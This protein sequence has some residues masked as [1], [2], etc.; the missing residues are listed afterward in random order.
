MKK[1]VSSIL[2]LTLSMAVVAFPHRNQDPQDP[3]AAA[4]PHP[5]ASA[6][7]TALTNKE[8]LEMMKAG[9]TAD[10]IV[11]KI[12]SSETNFDTTPAAL[13]ELKAANVPDTVILA[14]VKG[15]A[16]VPAGEGVVNV[17][18]GTEVEIQLTNNASGEELKVGNV[19]DFV[20]V[21]PV[22]V[23]GV[24][25][26]EKGAG[27]RARITTAKRAGHWGKAGKLEWAM[28]DVMAADG[29]RIPARFTQ[30][31]IGDSKGGTVAVAAVATTVLLGPLGLLWGLKKG[32]PA[33]IPAGNRYSVFVHG[34][35]KIKG[36]P[37]EAAA[38]DS[39]F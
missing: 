25:I 8:V 39:V 21:N 20:I 3:N 31:H 32:K 37:A 15:P 2:M 7:S 22:Q 28:Q 33:I 30:R 23:N 12:K 19:V 29:N 6:A 34:D 9:L 16:E 38:P 35:A 11:A 10:I 17:P 24:T 1:L 13:A 27:A 18:D 36:K 4:K 5:A 26:F 14:M